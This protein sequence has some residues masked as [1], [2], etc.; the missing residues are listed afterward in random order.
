MS[1]ETTQIESEVESITEA[2]TGNGDYYFEYV[3]PE[4]VIELLQAYRDKYKHP[5]EDVEKA[6]RVGFED[7][8]DYTNFNN[9]MYRSE[10][11][12]YNETHNKQT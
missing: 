4:K 10:K 5:R 11:Q 8:K 1:E 6:W 9:P 12:Y 7:G 2:F 3:K